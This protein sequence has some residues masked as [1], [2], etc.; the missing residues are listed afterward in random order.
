MISS[1]LSYTLNIKFLQNSLAEAESEDN[2]NDTDFA[3]SDQEE[4]DDEM[5]LEEQENHE[6]GNVDHKTEIDEL[7][8]DCTLS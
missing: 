6:L 8:K 4:D 2:Q 1:I 3:T 7:K 5:T